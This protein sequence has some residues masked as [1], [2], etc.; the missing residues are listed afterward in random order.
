MAFVSSRASC[1]WCGRQ[2][3]KFLFSW[4]KTKYN[5]IYKSPNNKHILTRDPMHLRRSRPIQPPLRKRRVKRRSHSTRTLREVLS[6]SLTVCLSTRPLP[7]GM[8]TDRRVSGGRHRA[9]DTVPNN[10]HPQH[11]PGHLSSGPGHPHLK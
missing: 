2:F 1:Q 3:L 9:R 7:Q 10:L 4:M 11:N 6:N 8:G 5:E